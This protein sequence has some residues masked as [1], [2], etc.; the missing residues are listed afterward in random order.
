MQD[1]SN[2]SPQTW[3]ETTNKV[4]SGSVEG[5]SGLEAVLKFR[6]SLTVVTSELVARV[7]AGR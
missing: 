4:V 2:T 1:Y 3:S 6:G 5:V 7:S